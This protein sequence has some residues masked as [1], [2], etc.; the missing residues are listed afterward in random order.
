[1]R[2]LIRYSVELLT[3]N[4]TQKYSPQTSGCTEEK[5]IP[6]KCPRGTAKA[7]SIVSTLSWWHR[8][9]GSPENTQNFTEFSP[10]ILSKGSKDKT[11]FFNPTKAQMSHG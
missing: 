2:D 7:L 3:Y 10:R 1:M 11:A 6:R 5:G 4:N 9:R 8:G